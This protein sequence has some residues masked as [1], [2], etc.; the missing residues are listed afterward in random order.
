MASVSLC[1]FYSMHAKEITPSARDVNR[2]AGQGWIHGGGYVAMVLKGASMNDGA[3]IRE[4][5]E[6]IDPKTIIDPH[7][8]DT[9]ELEPGHPGLGD[10]VYVQRRTEL[11]ALCRQHRLDRLGPPIIDYTAEETR[12]WR[13]VTPKLHE[14]HAKHACS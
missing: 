14:L 6:P 11:F 9:L 2:R 8:P 3:T 7:D 4:Y 12:I 13:E 5:G 10:P 1:Y